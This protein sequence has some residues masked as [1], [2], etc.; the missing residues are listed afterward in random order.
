MEFFDDECESF[1]IDKQEKMSHVLF[2]T[3]LTGTVSSNS[4]LTALITAVDEVA[5]FLR[6]EGTIRCEWGQMVK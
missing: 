4:R 1:L 3:H 6:D 2:F 5:K